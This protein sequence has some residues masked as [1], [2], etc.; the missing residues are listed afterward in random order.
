MPQP[1]LD[2]PRNRFLVYFPFLAVVRFKPV[3]KFLCTFAVIASTT[4]EHDVDA[5][6][7][8]QIT[9]VD[10]LPSYLIPRCASR[11]RTRLHLDVAINAAFVSSSDLDF[12][13]V[14]DAPSVHLRARAAGSRLR[15]P[16]QRVI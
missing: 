13:P 5:M 2:R 9:V 11:P 4:A 10:V 7:G 14:G 3:Q 16:N 15:A 1:I 6:L 8:I 12:I